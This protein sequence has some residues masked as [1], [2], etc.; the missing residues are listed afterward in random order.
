MGTT[1]EIGNDILWGKLV[2]SWAT[3]KNY[4]DPVNRCPNS[5]SANAR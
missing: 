1:L 2:K 5:Y 3:G 4:V